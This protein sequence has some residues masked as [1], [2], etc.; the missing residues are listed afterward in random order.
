MTAS[1]ES[2]TETTKERRRKSVYRDKLGERVCRA[3]ATSTV[4]IKR[5]VE[6]DKTL[7]SES[8]I[9]LWVQQNPRF[10]DEYKAARRAQAD[11]RMEACQEIAE[12]CVMEVQA[13]TAQNTAASGANAK[14]LVAAY[15]QLIEVQRRIA[16]WLAPKSKATSD[17]DDDGGPWIG[18][19]EM[20]MPENLDDLI[21]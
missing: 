3:I 8:T 11:A 16:A 15:Q 18:D 13:L 14:A 6:A 2:V 17:D 12:R 7:P 20:E 19:R 1:T 5:M 10:A 9:Y 4:G 21:C